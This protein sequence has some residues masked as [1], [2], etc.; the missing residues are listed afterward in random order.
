MFAKFFIERPRFAMVI[1]IVTSLAGVLSYRKLP[2][3]Q[4]P[5]ITP[6]QIVV[7]MRYPGANAMDIAKTI[8][9]PLE[10]QING[11]DGM[12]YMASNC[13]NAGNYSLAVT[14]EVGTDLNINM[15]KVQNRIQQATPR[16]PREAVDLGITVDTRSPDI[17]GFFYVTSPNGTFSSLQMSDYIYSSIRPEILRVP[18]VGNVMV[19]GARNSMRIWLDADR[20]SA[21]G[22][23]TEEVIQAI[24]RQNVQASAGAVGAEPAQGS[25]LV[26]TLTAQGRLESVQEFADIVV[27]PAGN[28]AL[29]RLSDIARIELGGDRYGGITGKYNGRE[30]AAFGVNQMPGSNAI[31][32]MREIQRELGKLQAR[33]PDDMI[34]KVSYDAT[35]FVQNAIDE[36]VMTLLLTFALVVGV[37]FLF[38]QDWRATLIPSLT[39]PVSI[40]STFV[41]LQVCG[42]SINILTLFALVLAIGVVVDD[43][44]VVVER[45]IHNIEM[46]K[47]SAREATLLAMEE[48]TGAVIATTLVLLA[49][50]VPVGFVGGISGRIYQQFALTLSAAVCFSTLNAL[51]LSPALCSILLR[52]KDPVRRGPLAWFNKGLNWFRDGYTAIAHTVAKRSLLAFLM[53]AATV[54]VAGWMYLSTPTAFLPDEDQSVMFVDLRLPEGTSEARTT[55]L[56]DGIVERIRALKGVDWSLAIYGR[57][58]M[59]GG[60]A[61]ENTG[62]CIVGL[63]PWDER[64]TPDL[65][66]QEIQKVTRAMMAEVV[67]AKIQVFTPPAIPGISANGGIDAWLQA[68][69]DSDPQKLESAIQQLLLAMEK[70]GKFAVCASTYTAQTPHLR[71]NIDRT[72]CEMFNVPVASL[73][74]TLQNYLGSRYVNDINI[75]TQVNTVVIQSD[76]ANRASPDDILKLYVRSQTGAMVP[77]GSLASFETEMA[78]RLVS[79]FN[80]YPA[81]PIMAFQYPFYSSSQAMTEIREQAGKLPLGYGTAWAGLSYQEDK[82]SGQVGVLMLAALVFGFLFLVAQYE[83]WTLPVSVMLSIFVAV[84]GALVGLKVWGLWLSIYAQLGLL[85]LIGLAGKNAILIVEFAQMRHEQGLS[86]VEAAADGMHQ[87]FRAVL[88]TAFTF[89]LGVLPMVYATGAGAASRVAIGVTVYAGMLAATAIGI[90]LIP[91]LYAVFQ[92]MRERAHALIGKPLPEAANTGTRE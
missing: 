59:A 69:D 66:V 2:I 19:F 34:C 55:E 43:A 87:R 68:Y 76:W 9:T 40:L 15:V 88:M 3:T 45:T 48:I 25:Q 17:L 51:T 71:L 24:Q 21:M 27:R 83:S 30:C 37:C 75:G 28:G 6:P 5:P 54:A 58:I 82:T 62:F 86:I 50:F 85:L 65:H 80:Q 84:A 7:A 35:R 18:G 91:G 38:L 73:F 16:L 26:W 42:F 92:R 22:M 47:L 14:F 64:T 1:A 46:K 23:S 31:D 74:A 78:P 67:G 89:I 79:R 72:K 12:L 41:V 39:I 33:M 49:I 20:M 61:A 13:D 70:S 53:L 56:V 10:E 90:T 44:I 8:A 11:V 77:V 57:S 29:V 32:T 52:H 60:A 81:A 63:A 4:Y 36:I